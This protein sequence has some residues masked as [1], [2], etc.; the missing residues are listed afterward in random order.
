MGVL[1]G[2]YDLIA[3]FQQGLWDPKPYKPN[4]VWVGASLG[5]SRRFLVS[6]RVPNRVS[7]AMRVSKRELQVSGFIWLEDCS[8]ASSF[9]KCKVSSGF[10]SW[11][12]C[13]LSGFMRSRLRG[14]Q[15]KVQEGRRTIVTRGFFVVFGLFCLLLFRFRFR[16]QNWGKVR[17]RCGIHGL[18]ALMA[19]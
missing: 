11:D 15:L 9:L 8:K 5:S 1:V 6:S 3:S 16:L 18:K 13:V 7:S 2:D 19:F 14:L 17:K 10:W 12:F 4:G